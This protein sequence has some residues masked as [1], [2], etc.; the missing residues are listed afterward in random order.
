MTPERWSQAKSIFGVAIDLEPARREAY[1]LETCGED[2]ILLREVISLLNADSAKTEIVNP[3]A[4][5][6][7]GP[8]LKERYRVERELGRGGLGMVLLARDETLHGRPVVIKMPLDPS[9]SDSWLSEKFAQEVK[10][11]ALI[12]H[13]GVVGALDSGVT[14][15]GRPFLVMQYVEGWPLTDCLQPQGM[16]FDRA[17][18]LLE[19]I[20]QA[21]GAAHARGIWHRD[22]KPAN[23]MV[24][25]LENGREHVRLIDFGIASVMESTAS[26]LKTRIAGTPS[27][28]SPEQFEGRVTAASD[29]YAM[30]VIAYELLTGSRPFLADSIIALHESQS[31]GVR[32]KPSELRPGLPKEVERLILQAL[33][34]RPEDRPKGAA[35]FG[36]A[37]ARALTAPPTAVTETLPAPTE[38]PPPSRRGAIVALAAAVILA[39]GGVYWKLRPEATRNTVSW[40]VMVQAGGTGPADA[41][42]PGT[43]LR[44]S[45]GFFLL[46]RAPQGYLYLLSDDP[47]KDSLVYLGSFQLRAGE[48][49]RVPETRPYK[50][51]EP[52]AFNLL[53]VWSRD[54]VAELEPL[55][56]WMESGGEIGDASERAR[57]RGLVNSLPQPA[58]VFGVHRSP[59]VETSGAR[60]A[61]KVR[62]EAK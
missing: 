36:A 9:P 4:R 20:G 57:V 32:V 29:I 8:L 16:P 34:F 49:N 24:Q 14:A 38:T 5:P 26:E 33:S 18:R 3:L 61:W 44:P 28:M 15:D 58:P 40:S 27:Y 37:L 55:V 35:A 54:T 21:L 12:D 56:R 10:A 23:I 50:F 41:A 19:Q 2:T 22:L 62:V 59:T 42:A 31:A 48:Q 11:L 43:P 47:D 53:C 39:A 13:P 17:A 6:A 45:D 51:D 1:L 30:G 46:V 52:G 60:M 25:A 7:T